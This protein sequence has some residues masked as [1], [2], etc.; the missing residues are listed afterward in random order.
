M[1]KFF[2]LLSLALS[3][4]VLSSCT[5]ESAG[6]HSIVDYVKITLLGDKEIFIGLGDE[7]VEPGFTATDKGVDAANK[8]EITITD[9][10]GDE[11]EAITTDN[12]GMY[13]I[14]YA[15]TSQDKLD[16]VTTRTVYVYDP[17]LS[18]SLEG[19]FAVD[20]TTSTC[21]SA[22]AAAG[23]KVFG[24]LVDYYND[25]GSY[26]G[27]AV[28]KFDMVFEQVCPGIYTCNDLLGGWYHAVQG[29]GGNYAA[30]YGEEYATYFDMTGMVSL[31]ADGSI[32]LASSHIQ[33]W[34]DGLSSVE[35]AK[36]TQNAAEPAAGDKLE[37]QV[38]YA[39]SVGP[40]QIYATRK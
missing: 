24:P 28:S 23:T 31:N 15:A 4:T 3:L 25:K 13:T 40:I 29:R 9:L 26:A 35:N 14:S 30:L 39:G 1:K 36:Y 22:P 27:Y 5:K 21:Q 18:I 10:Y 16:I 8:V 20:F 6:R 7:Y 33:A 12:P 19:T 11:V 2:I 34:G 38:M 32:A 37:L 17:E